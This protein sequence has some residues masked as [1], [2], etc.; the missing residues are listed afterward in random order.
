MYADRMTG[1]MQRAI[2]ETN[3]R[4]TMQIEYNKEHNITPQSI[5]KA[6]EPR[7]VTEEELPKEDI[8]NYIVDM[9]AEMHRAAK[10]LDF[11]KAVKL[12]DRIAKLRGE[13]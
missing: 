8:F 3:R 5:R 9:E 10:D 11:E 7:A 2:E 4:R 13:M 6:V 12:R 1:S